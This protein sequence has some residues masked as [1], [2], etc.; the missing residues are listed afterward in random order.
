MEK[1][2]VEKFQDEAWPGGWEEVEGLSPRWRPENTGRPQD[3]HREPRWGEEHV[4]W[5]GCA[6]N[7][8]VD[9][10]GEEAVKDLGRGSGGSEVSLE[11]WM[12]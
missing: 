12:F 4:R 8:G 6:E 2:G 11:K 9:E 7:K 1:V 5:E 3:G 10:A